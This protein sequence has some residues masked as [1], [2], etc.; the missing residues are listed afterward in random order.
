MISYV[1][2]MVI[3][4]ETMQ[5]SFPTHEEFFLSGC[6]GESQQLFRKSAKNPTKQAK[7]IWKK[8]GWIINKNGTTYCPVCATKLKTNK[9]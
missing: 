3:E 2:D 8:E 9:S 7:D 4:C 6:L 1:I 5:E